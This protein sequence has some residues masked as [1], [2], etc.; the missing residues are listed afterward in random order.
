MRRGKKS[1]KTFRRRQPGTRPVSDRRVASGELITVR[2]T[3]QVYQFQQLIPDVIVAQSGL[4]GN[5]GAF[6]YTISQLDQASSFNN[7]FDQYRI[8]RIDV[9][10]FPM[11]RANP[12]AS[13]SATLV[14]LIYVAVDYDDANAPASVATLREYENCTVHDDSCSFTVSFHPHV[15]IAAY[16]GAF[17]SFANQQSPWI[18]NASSGVLHYGVKWAVTGVTASQSVGQA[19]NVS[20]RYYFSMRNIR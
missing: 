6:G 20:A 17:T 3:N 10:F 16:S 4:S 7:L 12:L 13:T 18:D 5:T 11:F 14:P 8:D 2:E 1:P 9:T 15:A 19:W